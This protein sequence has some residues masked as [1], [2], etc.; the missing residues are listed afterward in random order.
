MSFVKVHRTGSNGSGHGRH[1]NRQLPSDSSPGLINPVSSPVGSESSQG[2]GPNNLESEPISL[3]RSVPPPSQ[4]NF[5][6]SEASPGT[7][8]SSK[9]FYSCNIMPR[10]DTFLEYNYQLWL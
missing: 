7:E 10:N 1:H 2:G 9:I 4:M 5:S 3:F 8:Y 6:H